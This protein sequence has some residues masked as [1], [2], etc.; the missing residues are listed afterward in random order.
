MAR[1]KIGLASP[2]QGEN[3]A[4]TFW[5]NFPVDF[6]RRFVERIS[7]LSL[8]FGSLSLGFLIF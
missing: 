5:E 7:S 2:L 6:S 4:K 3:L 1:A 8:G